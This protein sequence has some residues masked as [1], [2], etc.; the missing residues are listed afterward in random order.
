MVLS[1]KDSSVAFLQMVTKVGIGLKS[2]IKVLRYEDF[3]G[4]IELEI[5]GSKQIVSQK[6][7]ENV[8]VKLL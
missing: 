7:A 1:V 6:F 5:D 2:E 3:D 8:F 4:S